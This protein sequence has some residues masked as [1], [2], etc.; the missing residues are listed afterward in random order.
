ME[1]TRRIQTQDLLTG[2]SE[3]LIVQ[4]VKSRIMCILPNFTTQDFSEM[5]EKRKE[6]RRKAK[7]ETIKLVLPETALLLES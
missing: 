2:D 6:R 5:S 4:S 7:T 1:Q 3:R